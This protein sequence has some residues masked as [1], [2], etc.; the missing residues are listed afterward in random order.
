MLFNRCYKTILSSDRLTNYFTHY[1][2]LYFT[3]GRAENFFNSN[4]KV[5]F[6]YSFDTNRLKGVNALPVTVANLNNSKSNLI[7]NDD[8]TIIS[9]T[10]LFLFDIKEDKE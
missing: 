2:L 4:L 5:E 7:N 8:D 9:E 10:I 6:T 3:E 1:L